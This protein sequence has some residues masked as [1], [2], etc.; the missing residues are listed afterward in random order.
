MLRDLTAILSFS[1]VTDSKALEGNFSCEFAIRFSLIAIVLRDSFI[2]DNSSIGS[3]NSDSST[4]IEVFSLTIGTFAESLILTFVII[5]SLVIL[6]F[7]LNTDCSIKTN[8][9]ILAA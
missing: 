2:V 9:I 3:L 7:V 8:P 4:A 5:C 6:S 1:T